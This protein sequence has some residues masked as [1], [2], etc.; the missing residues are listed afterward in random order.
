[1]KIAFVAVVGASL[2]LTTTQVA[3]AATTPNKTLKASNLVQISY[4][5]IFKLPKSG[6]AKIPVRYQIGKLELDESSFT[7][8][9][10][11]DQDRHIGEAS[12]YGSSAESATKAMPKSG[13][14]QI[15]VCRSAWY[16]SVEEVQSYP[17]YKG[18]YDI[19]LSA[20]GSESADASATMKFSE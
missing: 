15:K 11:D 16:D 14:L 9:I 10:S 6:C 20:T 19:Y 13:T 2:L 5:T 17:T 18:I 7:V 8:V 4:P 12:W 1:M 3:G